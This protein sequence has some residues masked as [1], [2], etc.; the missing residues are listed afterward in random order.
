M[1][2]S[3]ILVF[4]TRWMMIVSMTFMARTVS[5]NLILKEKKLRGWK[6]EIESA[7]EGG[8]TAMLTVKM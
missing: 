8:Y 4:L 1:N 2:D 5:G 6:S 3:E 7:S